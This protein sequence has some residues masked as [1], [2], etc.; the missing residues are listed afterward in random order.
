MKIAQ[1]AER[2]KPFFVMEMAKAA[3]QL[4]AQGAEIAFT[5]Q[6]EA[7]RKRVLPLAQSPESYQHRQPHLDLVYRQEETTLHS[8]SELLLLRN[9]RHIARKLHS[10]HHGLV[11]LD[12]T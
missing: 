5:Y 8:A 3:Q 12:L 4:A 6:G 9:M 7:L 10:R 11:E 1:R 2:I